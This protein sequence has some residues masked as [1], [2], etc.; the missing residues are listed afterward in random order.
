MPEI[1]LLLA[2]D[3]SGDGNWIVGTWY[4]ALDTEPFGL[5]PGFPL[6][7]LAIFNR[8]GTY[9][10]LD[11]NDFGQAT[12]L[13]TQHSQQFGSWKINRHGTVVATSLFL[14]ADLPTGELISWEKV[15]MTLKRTRGRNVVRGRV[16]LSILECQN[17]LPIPT[18]LTCPDPIAS[19]GDFVAA[20]PADIEITFKRLRPGR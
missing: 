13:N 11:A 1:K 15:N 5:P 12:A 20:P 8:D 17:M 19:A 9:Q 4:L 10:W 18:P 2:E 3:S 6:S 7:G 16:N 14:S